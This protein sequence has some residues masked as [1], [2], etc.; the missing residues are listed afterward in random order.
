MFCETSAKLRVVIHC[1]ILGEN[2][3]STRIECLPLCSYDGWN[4]RKETERKHKLNEI[5]LIEEIIYIGILFYSCLTYIVL[6]RTYL[7]DLLLEMTSYIGL[8]KRARLETAHCCFS[9][10]FM[11]IV[12]CKSSTIHDILQEFISCVRCIIHQVLYVSAQA[13][14]KGCQVWRTGWLVMVSF[15][16]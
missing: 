7:S 15:S 4:G 1:L 16:R 10:I 13:G 12:P 14:I 5:G 2:V 8:H 9:C 3:I 6:K 11:I